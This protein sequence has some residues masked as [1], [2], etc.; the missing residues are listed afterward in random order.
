MKTKISIRSISTIMLLCLVC[1][2]IWSFKSNED[3]DNDAVLAS[4]KIYCELYVRNQY[5]MDKS[6][7]FT[8]SIKHGNHLV[9]AN[10]SVEANKVKSF[11][12]YIDALNYLGG[13]GWSLVL[14]TRHTID[15]NYDYEDNYV[16]EK[17]IN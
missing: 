11:T 5:K 16:L 3:V 13:Q 8:L 1:M 12:N 2:G 15:M 17:T 9:Y 14:A 7:H 6:W 4:K 10:K